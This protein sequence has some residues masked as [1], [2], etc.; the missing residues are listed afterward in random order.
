[1]FQDVVQLKSPTWIGV[2]SIKV[3]RPL[4]RREALF[5]VM[6]LKPD[7]LEIATSMIWSVVTL[8]N[9]AMSNKTLLSNKRNSRPISFSV[10][11]KGCKLGLGARAPL[12]PASHC[13]L[14]ALLLIEYVRV[15]S[16]GFTPFALPTCAHD[17]RSLP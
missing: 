2:T 15:P 1:L 6:L 9:A 4:L 16:Y 10:T 12:R 14:K 3:S 7:V 5:S 11:V 8:S 13:P 17:A